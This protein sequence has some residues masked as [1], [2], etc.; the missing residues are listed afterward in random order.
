MVRNER[1]TE[2]QIQGDTTYMSS[3]ESS[4]PQRQ[5][6]LGRGRGESVLMGTDIGLGRFQKVLRM[7]DGGGCTTLNVL[8]ALNVHL[9]IARMVR[10]MLCAPYHNFF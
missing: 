9:A 4:N 10:F 8:N 5:E 7:D 1:V 2:G 3:P 6:G